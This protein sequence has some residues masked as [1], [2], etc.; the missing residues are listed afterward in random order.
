[1]NQLPLRD[2]HLPDAVAW[3]PPAIGWWLLPLLIIAVYF[4]MRWLIKRLRYKPMNKRV[5]IEF[6][7]IQQAYKQQRDQQQLVADISVLLRRSCISYKNRN[8]SA[9]LTG[10]AWIHMLNSISAVKLPDSIA[11]ALLSAPYRRQVDIDADEL[12]AACGEWI[13][14][15]PKHPQE[16]AR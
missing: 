3:W 6:A 15:L 11:Q 2:I 8:S 14:G 12:L 16:Q 13:E 1:M 4:F 10:D 9:S 5:Q 7:Q